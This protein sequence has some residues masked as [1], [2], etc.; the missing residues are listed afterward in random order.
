VSDES[1]RDV[2]EELVAIKAVADAL[3][4][5]TTASRRHVISYVAD[6][7]GI[8]APS[9]ATPEPVPDALQPPVLAETPAPA[10]PATDIRTL[11]EQKAPKTAN[12]MA[13]LVAYYISELILPVEDRRAVINKT[14]IEKYFKQASFRLPSRVAQTLP[15]AARAGYFD[16][17]DRGQY[18]LNPVGYNLVAHGL[19]SKGGESRGSRPRKAPAKKAVAKKAPVKKATP[20][21]VK[22]PT[23]RPAKKRS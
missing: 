4:P 18:K 23:K 3:E 17:V 6:A 20:R 2:A 10:T 16:T 12:E 21:P 14:D 5:L 15:D 1:A 11:K 13:A 19:P 7:L 22:K 8:A 9:V